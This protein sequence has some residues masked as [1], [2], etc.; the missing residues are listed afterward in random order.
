MAK[1]RILIFIHNGH[2]TYDLLGNYLISGMSSSKTC[3]DVA[4]SDV[5]THSGHKY[6]IIAP[7]LTANGADNFVLAPNYTGLLKMSITPVHPE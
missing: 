1:S 2:C 7:A 3:L 5:A 6:S 4:L